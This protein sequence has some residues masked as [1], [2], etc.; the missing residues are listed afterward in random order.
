MSAAT[1][2]L[3]ILFNASNWGGHGIVRSEFK[4]AIL[5]LPYPERRNYHP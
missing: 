3:I 4:N 1:A 5:Y 2:V